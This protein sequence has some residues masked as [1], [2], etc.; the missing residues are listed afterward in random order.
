M[1]KFGTC[2]AAAGIAAATLLA[3][4]AAWA[5]E[6]DNS[7]LSA[8]DILIRGRAIGV[9]PDTSSTVQPIGGN[10]DIGN[11]VMPEIDASYFVTDNIAFEIIAATTHHSVT[12]HGSSSG[13]LDL[14]SVWLLPPTLTAQWHF[15]P[16]ADFNPY[17]GAG[18]NYTIFYGEHAGDSINKIRYDNHVG[19]ALQAGFDYN[20][21]NN[22]FANVDLKKLFVSTTAHINDNAVVANVDIDP[23]IIG[24][25]V[26]YRF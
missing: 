26:G 15:L 22:W 21:G 2:L 3:A 14:G 12:D 7:G 11:A 9:L 23:W 18:I 13:N 24:A 4:P 16:H 25:G 19:W 20:M 5:L 6:G 1:S 8:G 10:V 17:V